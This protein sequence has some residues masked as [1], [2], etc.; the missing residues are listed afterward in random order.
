[1]KSLLRG[2]MVMVAAFAVTACSNNNDSATSIQGSVSY[3]MRMALPPNAKLIVSLDDITLNNGSAISIDQQTFETEDKSI[4]LDFVF[5]VPAKID[6]DKIYALSAS[7]QTENGEVILATKD[8]YPVLTDAN[9]TNAVQLQLFSYPAVTPESEMIF[10]NDK[11]ME[12]DMEM[13]DMGMDKA[14]GMD[15]SM[16]KGMD[17]GMDKT[18]DKGM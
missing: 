5:E 10:E 17:K 2:L 12:M 4:P 13:M 18:M 8:I 6:Q 15:K 14:N 11:D 3:L 16:D 9:K 1:M 7:I